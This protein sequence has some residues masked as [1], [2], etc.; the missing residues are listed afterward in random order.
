MKIRSKK[1]K[2]LRI[3]QMTMIKL[4]GINS[5]LVFLTFQTFAQ[6]VSVNQ[7]EKVYKNVA[8][9][10][11]V[12]DMFSTSTTLQ[13][14]ANPAIALF[15]G[16]GWVSG[17]RKEFYEVCRRYARKGFVTFS[18]QYRLSRNE[19]NTYP[20]PDIT[21]V[22]CVKD[23][24]SAI[25]WLRANAEELKIDLDKIVVGG[26]S[27][28]GQLALSTALIDDVNEETDN[29]EISPVPNALLLFSS[30]V[31]TIEAWI[32]MIMGDRRNEIWSI[33][34]YH[35]LKPNMPPAIGFRGDVDNQ[36]LP[37]TVNFFRTKMIEL[38]NYYDLI[39]YK[40]RGHYLAEGNEKYA[41][42]FDEEILERTDDFLVK[43]GFMKPG[44]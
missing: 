44:D 17:D 31:N 14:S 18:F 7:E 35:N 5:L 24:R 20:D 33:S 15:H 4:I 32:D 9:R 11:L 12:V 16:G 3:K 30:N 27:A 19:D 41:T 36:V 29:L 23:A 8:G 21:L 28:G 34:P 10:E 38:G 1:A 37:Y 13:K 39:T 43:F 25:R 6:E 40:G 22:E 2:G 42:Y 26:Q